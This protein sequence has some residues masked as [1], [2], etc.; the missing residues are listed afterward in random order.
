MFKANSTL[1]L[2]CFLGTLAAGIAIG[3]TSCRRQQQGGAVG[4]GNGQHSY[5]ELMAREYPP[6]PKHPVALWN[7]AVTA[8][9]EGAGR[10]R[11]RVCRR[12]LQL[13]D[14]DGPGQ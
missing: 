3:S 9:I 4:P 13:R 8:S 11:G 7:G 6:L 12:G 5:E 14:R 2:R 1:A 10:P